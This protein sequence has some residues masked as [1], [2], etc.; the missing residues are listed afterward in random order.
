MND[1]EIRTLDTFKRVRNFDATHDGLFPAGT[2]GRELFDAIAG[3]VNDI[4]GHAAAESSGR[5]AARQGTAGKATSRAAIVEDLTIIR[6]TARSMAVVIPGLDDKFRL[7]RKPTDRELLDTARAFLA[8]ATPLRAEFQRREVPESVFQDLAADI[9]A[10]ESALN[11]QYTGKGESTTAGVSID[12][13]FERGTEALRQL[14]PI[15]RNKLR[16]NP[17]ALAA[18]QAAKRTERPA[19]RSKPETPPVTPTPNQ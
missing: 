5:G 17:A 9:A 14:D 13:A 18:W 19:R 12:A 3:C 7:P 11:A 1:Q 2:L 4:E 6:R 16:D 15:V 10:F 8:D